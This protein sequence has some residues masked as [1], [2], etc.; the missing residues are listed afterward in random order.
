MGSLIALWRS[1]TRR[2]LELVDRKWRHK[3]EEVEISL[4]F[5]AL[6]IRQKCPVEG[7]LVKEV[8]M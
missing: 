3:K 6:C 1:T 4:L 2:R 5:C 7:S 8:K